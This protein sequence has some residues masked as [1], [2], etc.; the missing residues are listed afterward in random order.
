MG[1]AIVRSIV[2]AHGGRVEVRSVPGEGAAFHVRLP[3]L[4]G[5]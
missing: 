1:P 3:A 2:T 4:R 5:Q